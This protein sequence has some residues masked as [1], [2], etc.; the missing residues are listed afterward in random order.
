VPGG[1]G[2]GSGAGNW[3]ASYDSTYHEVTQFTGGVARTTW[4]AC[5][6][7][8]GEGRGQVH[9]A[10]VCPDDPSRSDDSAPALERHGGSF[11][12]AVAGQSLTTLRATTSWHSEDPLFSSE[13]RPLL[14][15]SLI[16]AQE[17]V[18]RLAP[19]SN[20]FRVVC[21]SRPSLDRAS[22]CTISGNLVRSL[23]FRDF[24]PPPAR[25]SPSRKPRSSKRIVGR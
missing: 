24:H 12:P 4:V 17:W 18:A 14:A 5:P 10:P 15:N 3:Q 6:E 16:G 19:S 20:N 9:E 2:G 22:R 25:S 7:H 21:R 1:L 23:W 8:G 11:Q 13:K